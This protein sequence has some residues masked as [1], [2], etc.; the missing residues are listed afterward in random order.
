MLIMSLNKLKFYKQSVT[1]S[2][3]KMIN[4]NQNAI[5][6]NNKMINYKVKFQYSKNINNS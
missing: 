2:N 4:Y 6:Y 3:N 5:F 1:F